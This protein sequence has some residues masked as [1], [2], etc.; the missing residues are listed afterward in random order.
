MAT[1]CSALAS[2]LE[3]RLKDRREYGEGKVRRKRARRNS[4][5]IADV[6][7]CFTYFEHINYA[8]LFGVGA[9]CPPGSM[10]VSVGNGTDPD[11]A[12]TQLCNDV[13][14][15]PTLPTP[16][17]DYQLRMFIFQDRFLNIVGVSC[18]YWNK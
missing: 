3:V 14:R 13:S 10:G 9:A 4:Y 5:F 12:P 11:P 17:S 15:H 7:L 18:C 8:N 2:A 1:P 6:G 16:N